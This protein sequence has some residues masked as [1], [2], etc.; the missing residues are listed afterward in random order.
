[1]PRHAQ[2]SRE[3]DATRLRILHEATRI[4]GRVGLNGLS[5]RALGEGV[6]LT[7]GALYRYFPSKQDLLWSMWESALADLKHGFAACTEEKDPVRAIRCMLGAYASFALHDLDR[8]RALFLE[9]DQGGLNLLDRDP[10]ALA[11]Y[12]ALREAIGLAK[13]SSTLFSGDVDRLTQI[14]WAA[15]HGALTLLVTVREIDFGDREAFVSE[16]IEAVLRGLI[17]AGGRHA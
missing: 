5:M 13:S 8:F 1:M 4:V 12:L 16:T 3:F 7:P 14:L 9:N 6:G 2:P 11:P 17:P 10:E 15:T